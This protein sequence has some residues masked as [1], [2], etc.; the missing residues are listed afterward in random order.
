[1]KYDLEFQPEQRQ[2]RDQMTRILLGFGAIL[3][4]LVIAS[5]FALQKDGFLDRLLGDYFDPTETETAPEEDVW[6][7]KGEARFLLCCTDNAVQKLRFCA[8]AAFDAETRTIALTPFSAHMKASTGGGGVTLEQALA[9][10][11]VKELKTAVEALLGA[12]IDR[13][14][15]GSDNQFVKTI[16]DRTANSAGSV[17]VVLEKSIRYA[18]GDFTL[19]L[20][21]GSLRLQGDMLLRYFRYLG[22]LYKGESPPRGQAEL[23]GQVLETYLTANS[24]ASDA[25]L[26]K[27]FDALVNLLQTD[28]SVTDFYAQRELILALLADSGKIT[29]TVKGS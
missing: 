2:K 21:E 28:I 18:V 7:Y 8:V 19:T 16:N 1:M 23:L 20:A 22:T 15:A 13:Y 11:G 26:G 27:C 10:G 5:A 25:A 6:A 24:G 14:I 4:L 29:I 3:L 17:P 9:Q 12:P